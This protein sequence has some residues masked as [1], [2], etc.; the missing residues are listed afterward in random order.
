[1]LIKLDLKSC[2]GDKDSETHALNIHF[3]D[4][5]A[6][7]EWIDWHKNLK[8]VTVGHSLAAGQNKH[9]ML[10]ALLHGDMLHAFNQAVLDDGMRTNEHLQ[11]VSEVVTKHIFHCCTLPK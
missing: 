11:A 10:H 5:G 7:H 9:N 1:M 4:S 2:P 6:P 8:K 3:F